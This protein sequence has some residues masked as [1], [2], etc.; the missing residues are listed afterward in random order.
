[1]R[2]WVCVCVSRCVCVHGVCVICAYTFQRVWGETTLPASV[3]VCVCVC[4]CVCTSAYLMTIVGS[5]MK[6]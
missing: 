4:V 1:M 6:C 3:R 2:A 5:R